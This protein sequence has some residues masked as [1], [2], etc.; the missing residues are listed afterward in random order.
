M[1]QCSMVDVTFEAKF[2]V[3][4][5]RERSGGGGGDRLALCDGYSVCDGLRL[6]K[7]VSIVV[8][9]RI[10]KEYNRN[11]RQGLKYRH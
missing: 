4:G 11:T 10:K 6:Q 3:V 2:E 1:G 9:G 7:V 5:V 8:L